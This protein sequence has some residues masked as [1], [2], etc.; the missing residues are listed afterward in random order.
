MTPSMINHIPIKQSYT[1]F[2]DT[3]E[4]FTFDSITLKYFE[5]LLIYKYE[6]DISFQRFICL[7]LIK[8]NLR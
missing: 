8:L 6:L 4:V 2:Q 3:I 5:P 7:N 1:A